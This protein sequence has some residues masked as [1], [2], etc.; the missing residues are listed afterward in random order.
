[1][2]LIELDLNKSIEQNASDYYDK[3]KKLKKKQEGAKEALAESY[4]KLEK[5][6][7]EQLKEERKQEKKIEIKKEWYEKFRWFFSSEGFLVIGGR[8]AT[9]NEI[10]VKKH[11][12]KGDIVFHTDMVGSPFF[13]IKSDNK[14]ITE[15]TIKEVADA[16]VTFSRAWKLGMQTSS[17]FYCKP[18]QLTKEALPGE[19]V[20]RGGFVTKG[21]LNY[22]ENKINCAIGNYNGK[23]MA[24]PISAVK[25]NC[26]NYFEIKPGRDKASVVAKKINKKL[27]LEVD[28]IV[29][30]LP[31][32]GYEL[33]KP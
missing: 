18:D 33:K 27:E 24:G 11:T 4:G 10:V 20:P 32:G 7:K 28:D 23:A 19:Y 21:K 12:D 25:K 15:Q 8:D 9:S 29:R 14:E 17:V 30:I 26:E 13:V 2:A 3:A 6:E 5:L 1:M 22:V 31:T 16:T